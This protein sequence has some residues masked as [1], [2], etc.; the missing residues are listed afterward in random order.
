[1][2]A[3]LTCAPSPTPSG[4]RVPLWTAEPWKPW[5]PE[6]DD[7]QEYGTAAG[8]IAAPG[9][10]RIPHSPVKRAFGHAAATIAALVPALTPIAVAVE[11]D[12][13]TSPAPRRPPGGRRTPPR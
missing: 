6:P 8:A 4:L 2:P 13:D 9:T 7:F 10:L 1:M 3:S 12:T 5:S 11:R